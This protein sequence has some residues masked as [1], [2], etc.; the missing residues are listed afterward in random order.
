M[1]FFPWPFFIEAYLKQARRFSL[2]ALRDRVT[3]LNFRS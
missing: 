1:E 3:Q 2:R